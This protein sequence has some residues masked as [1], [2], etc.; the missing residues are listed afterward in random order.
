[1]WAHNIDIQEYMQTSFD[2][3]ILIGVHILDTILV[4]F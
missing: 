3:L 2:M 4:L 1:M